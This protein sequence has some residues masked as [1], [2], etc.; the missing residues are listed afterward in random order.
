MR[1]MAKKRSYGTLASEHQPLMQTR[2]IRQEKRLR[3]ST[4]FPLRYKFYGGLGVS[5]LLICFIAWT[6]NYR[7]SA[8]S[9]T[10]TPTGPSRDI[11]HNGQLPV[12]LWLVEHDPDTH[13]QALATL[14]SLYTADKSLTNTSDGCNSITDT[15]IW[16]L[17]RAS[18][19]DVLLDN[20]S[21]SGREKAR[22][23]GIREADMIVCERAGFDSTL[24]SQ[25][26]HCRVVGNDYFSQQDPDRRPWLPAG[27]FRV[28]P[29]F[30][31][32]FRPGPWSHHRVYS[33]LCSSNLSA[34]TTTAKASKSAHRLTVSCVDQS[35][36]VEDQVTSQRSYNNLRSSHR[37]GK[38][39]TGSSDALPPGLYVS[40]N[41]LSE[42]YMAL[43]EV[44]G[45]KDHTT[46]ER[47]PSA[48]AGVNIVATTIS[49]A[50][51][52]LVIATLTVGYGIMRWCRMRRQRPRE[53]RLPQWQ[54]IEL[55]IRRSAALNDGSPRGPAIAADSATGSLPGSARPTYGVV[56]ETR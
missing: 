43:S 12:Y 25:M 10:R 48:E 39:H 30:N 28:S 18:Y 9:P 20:A 31:L 37:E 38:R 26:K 53:D 13:D 11:R 35:A 27:V 2:Q 49:V 4:G 8:G 56:D 33:C 50:V 34:V 1:D 45:L 29:N 52:L 41:E 7:A 22:Y 32:A 14:K 24:A 51:G 19:T 54:A 23:Q 6:G 3:I 46:R 5:L 17:D 16:N 36:S 21:N 55:L 42:S 47:I 44:L 15:S 40:P